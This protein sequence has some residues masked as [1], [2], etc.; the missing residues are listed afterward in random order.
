[1]QL[2]LEDFYIH[3]R[4]N[5]LCFHSMRYQPNRDY[6]SND[7]IQTP[8]Y[9]AEKLIEHF[10]PSG[11]ILEPCK[12]DGNILSYLP[13]DTLWCEI[14]EGRDFLDWDKPVDW[15]ITNPPWSK[16]RVFLNHSMTIAN[17]IVFLMTVNHVWTKAR[18]RDIHATGFGI[19]E[20]SLADM[21][22]SFP[23]SGF[24]L[25]AIHISKGWLGRITLSSLARENEEVPTPASRLRPR[26]QDMV[27]GRI[28]PLK[29][30]QPIPVYS[31]QS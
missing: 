10:Q 16:I 19:K 26:R 6:V 18:I 24:Q 5:Q 2:I 22:K 11:K 17:D 4:K 3:L 15:I 28:D 13:E 1:M 7:E 29:E 30:T 20:I 9:L 31:E 21:P 23:Q 8:L 25:G 14:N 27:H 12:G